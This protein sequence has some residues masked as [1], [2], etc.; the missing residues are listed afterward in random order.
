MSSASAVARWD[1]YQ[2]ERFPLAAHAPLVAA[3]SASAVCFS[4]LLRGHAATPSPAALVVAFVTSL[5]FFLQLRI[6]DEFKDAE[7]DARFRPYRPVPR[8]LVTLRELAWLGGGAGVVQLGLAL[9]LE[10]SLVWLLVPAWTCLVLM[11]REFFVPGWL[12]TRPLVYM[13]S[14]MLILPLVDLYATACDWRVAGERSAPGGLFW[15]LAVSYLNGIVIEIGRKTRAPADEEY[16]VETY[17][18]MWGVQGAAHAWMFAVLLTGAAAWEASTRIGTGAPTLLMLSVLVA[19]CAIVAWRFAT[20]ARRGAGRS[21]E[22]MAG[23]WTVLMYIGLGAAPLAL[24]LWRDA[25]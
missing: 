6:A 4:S 2:R 25:R 19:A 21:I 22:V 23:V 14:H 1:A 12:R 3:F 17:S 5:L 16:G 11:T 10:A 15:F 8:G 20:S 9:W 7:D 13:T 24:A 18:T